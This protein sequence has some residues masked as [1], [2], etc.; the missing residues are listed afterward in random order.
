MKICKWVL[1]RGDDTCYSSRVQV[2]TCVLEDMQ[3]MQKNFDSVLVDY[4]P[5]S[6]EAVQAAVLFALGEGA[7]RV[8]LGL[9]HL[10]RLDTQA[11][12]GLITLL[13]RARDVGGELSLQVTRPD[14][15]RS[16]RVTALDRLFPVVAAA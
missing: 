8:V 4:H 1:A 10:D 11:V 7:P 13:R 5:E 2:P 16:L 15:L 3:T 12:R 14:L 9:D 6:I